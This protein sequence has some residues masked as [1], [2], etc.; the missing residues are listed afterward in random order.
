MVMLTIDRYI[1]DKCISRGDFTHTYVVLGPQ[2]NKLLHG[3]INV[4]MNVSLKKPTTNGA[5][6]YEAPPRS[7]PRAQQADDGGD[8]TVT[9]GTRKK[10]STSKP[11]RDV[12]A[13]KDDE[14]GDPVDEYYEPA[15]PKK[16]VESRAPKPRTTTKTSPS[17]GSKSKAQKVANRHGLGSKKS[18]APMSLPR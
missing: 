7:K 14:M 16:A 9:I 2:G 11:G 6:R 1:E 5:A 18:I 4:K 15:R 10:A 13:V 17:S 3:N 8:W 12:I